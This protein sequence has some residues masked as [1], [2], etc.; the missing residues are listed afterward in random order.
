[1]PTFGQHFSIE[2]SEDNKK[3]LF[4]PRGFAHGFVVLSDIAEFFY[5]CDNYYEPNSEEGIIYNDPD[6]DID[7]KIS[8]NDTI[9]SSKDLE[10]KPFSFYVNS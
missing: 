1:M 9:V 7:W 5:K 2:L 6:L 10:N 4:I 3:Q 8:L